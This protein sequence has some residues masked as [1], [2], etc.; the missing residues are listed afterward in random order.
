MTG[1]DT[2]IDEDGPLG[3][4]V[5]LDNIQRRAVT[6]ARRRAHGPLTYAEQLAV[7]PDERPQIFRSDRVKYVDTDVLSAARARIRNVL[8]TFDKF[9]VLYSGGKDSH[10]V[11]HLVRSVMDDMG[12]TGPLDLVFQDEEL[13]PD[14]VLQHVASLRDQPNR[15]RLH[16]V[17]VPLI[18]S[19]FM[20]GDQ[21]PYVQWDET[22]E[23]LRPKPDYAITH[24]H[25]SNAPM[26]QQETQ[27]YLSLRLGWKGRIAMF[28][29]I[30]AQE[31]LTRFRSCNL[32]RNTNNYVMKD[33]E[34]KNTWLIKPIYDWSTFDIFRYFYDHNI[35]YCKIYDTEM[36]AGTPDAELRVSTPVHAQA[37]GY[38]CRLRVMY[39]TFWSQLCQIFPDLPA[40][41][42]YWRHLDRYAI[43]AKYPKS[44]AGIM[45]Y[46]EDTVH[47]PHSK[48]VA[49]KCVRTAWMGKENNKRL[50]KFSDPATGAC[51]GYPLLHVFKGVVKGIYLGGQISIHSNPDA[52]M[53]AYERA[54]EVEAKVVENESII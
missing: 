12:M 11:M 44:F 41:E 36:F 21:I 38:L 24:L 53:V 19:L 7:P 25:P 42:R 47:A 13:I 35:A 40:H 39:P 17:A 23:W 5:L 34:S 18:G 8:N 14:D 46:I 43:I 31:S 3:A 10:V 48:A 49:I 51:F 30:R 52:H 20:L 54:S 6:D 29:G 1:E 9:A 4:D 45:Q 28:N 22:R 33:P 50:G 27:Q 37:H 32:V 26:K 16:Y 15:Y 2:I